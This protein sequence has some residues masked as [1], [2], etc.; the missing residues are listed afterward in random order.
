MKSRFLLY[1]SVV[2]LIV[3]GI[4]WA[5][6]VMWHNGR[7]L[8]KRNEKLAMLTKKLEIIQTKNIN[9]TALQDRYGILINEFRALQKKIPTLESFAQVQDFI[10]DMADS[11]G[12]EIVWQQPFLEDTLPPIKDLLELNKQHIERYTVQVKVKGDFIAIGT[13]LE[14][15]I[16]GDKIINIKKLN[17][18]TE[19]KKGGLLFCDITLYTYIFSSNLKEST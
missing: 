19:F 3:S 6:Q 7:E 15:L 9:N 10:R 1:I 11:S 5:Y 17:L 2:T 16:N 18:Q 14:N 12:V 4:F 13:F 8:A